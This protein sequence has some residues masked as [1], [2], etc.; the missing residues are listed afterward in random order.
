[1]WSEC[2]AG[3]WPLR[4][5][6]WVGFIFAISQI[7]V[8][9]WRFVSESHLLCYKKVAV[10]SLKPFLLL[11]AHRC[12]IGLFPLS[13]PVQ[14]SFVATAFVKWSLTSQSFKAACWLP[15]LICSDL[16][17]LRWTKIRQSRNLMLKV[18]FSADEEIE[19]SDGQRAAIKFVLQ[20]DENLHLKLRLIC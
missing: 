12:N 20:D 3:S 10:R 6:C 16:L 8:W 13:A 9:E 5:I 18:K 14:I 4:G 15:A 11:S 7:D 1:M 2:F 19:Q 17:M